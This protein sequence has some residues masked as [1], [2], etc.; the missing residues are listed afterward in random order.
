M[1]SCYSLKDLDPD[2]QKAWKRLLTTFFF[3]FFLSL[4]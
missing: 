3:F 1:L 2:M 4:G